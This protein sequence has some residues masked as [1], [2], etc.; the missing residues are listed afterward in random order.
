MSVYDVIKDEVKIAQKVDNVELY[1]M[2]LDIQKESLD[3]LDENQKLKEKI[4]ELED[5]NKIGES[6]IFKDYFYYKIDDKDLKEPYCSNC[7]DSDKK[8][9]RIHL[10][11]RPMPGRIHM[12]P[13]C[14][15][16]V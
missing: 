3:L 14:K 6:L 16:M 4:G 10:N 7:W 11:V 9:I 2:L 15:M 1:R 13:N 8:L 12:C 5:N